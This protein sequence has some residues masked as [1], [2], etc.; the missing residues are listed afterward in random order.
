ML[1]LGIKTLLSRPAEKA[2]E[3]QPTSRTDLPG[4]YLSTLFLTL[5]NPMTILSFV[6]IFAGAGI[7]TAGS[8]TGSAATIVLG[9]FLGS[10]A[11]WLLLTTGV[12]LLRERFNDRWLLWVNRLSGVIIIAFALVVLLT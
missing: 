4:F 3:I 12:G 9:V 8:N 6:A 10:A 5:T 1:Y 2:A 11:W 7:A